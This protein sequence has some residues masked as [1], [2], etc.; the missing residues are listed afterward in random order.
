[1]NERTNCK[2]IKGPYLLYSAI[3]YGTKLVITKS[4]CFEVLTLILI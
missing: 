2:R 1:M 3:V 4:D